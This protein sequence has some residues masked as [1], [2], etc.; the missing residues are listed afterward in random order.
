[1]PN[2]HPLFR[3]FAGRWRIDA[4]R[5]PPNLVIPDLIRNP[6]R[7]SEFSRP[8]P[9]LPRPSP[10]R[11]RGGC[12]RR[13]APEFYD[14]GFRVKPGMTRGFLRLRLFLRFAGRASGDRCQETGDRNSCGALRRR[15]AGRMMIRPYTLC[16]A[17]LRWAF[18]KN[19]ARRNTPNLSSFSVSP[20]LWG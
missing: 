14:S 18:P 5:K 19:H 17:R 12:L 7:H 2:T 13:V 20:C 10:A 6:V 1:M 9:P 15:V 16:R 11:G 3:V 4:R 8:P